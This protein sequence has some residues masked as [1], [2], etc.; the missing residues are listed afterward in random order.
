MDN[1]GKSKY[2][3]T[4][5]GGNS[6]GI[7]R[8]SRFWL[9]TEAQRAIFELSAFV[10]Y[11][12]LKTR[13][14]N[15]DGHP[16]M[17]LPGFM[18]S[19]VS[20]AP[21]RTLLKRLRYEAYGWKLGRNYGNGSDLNLLIEQIEHL[22]QTH[23]SRV[24]LIGWSLGGVFAREIAKRRPHLIRQIIMMGSPFGGVLRSNHASWLYYVLTNGKGPDDIDRK[25]LQYL[26]QPALVPTTAI[27]SK[28]DGIV[29]WELCVES[30][31]SDIHE[32]IEVNGSHLG[33][34][35]NPYVLDIIVDRLQLMRHNWSKYE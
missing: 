31:D 26:A 29:P 14:K 33:F 32:N 28:Q 30:H 6:S 21:L 25:I 1:F 2:M 15:G 18:A 27:Y 10:P 11:M 22:Y 24:S 4:Q 17:V 3:T 34:G 12:A 5:K 23:Q 8:P 9:A 13:T 16:V 19:D 35:V 20:T 7:K